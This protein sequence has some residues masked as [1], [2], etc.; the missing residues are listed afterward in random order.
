M[1]SDLRNSLNFLD[2]IGFMNV[3]LPFLFAFVVLF[4]ILEKT[5]VFGTENGKS[6]KNINAMTAFIISFIFISFTSYVDS[7]IKYL[8]I[9][10][11]MLIFI[12]GLAYLFAIFKLDMTIFSKKTFFTMILFIIAIVAFFY[13]MGLLNGIPGDFIFDLI[14]NPI[15]LIILFFFGIIWFMTSGEPD[16]V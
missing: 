7:L 2:S 8:Q 9:L 15:V 10:S 11:M 12:M 13:S 6:K 1:V 16:V 4:G 14:L 5:K 3:L